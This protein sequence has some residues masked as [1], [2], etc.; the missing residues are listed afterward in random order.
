[1]SIAEATTFFGWCTVLSMSLLVITAVCLAALQTLAI[2]VHTALY[3]I[4]EDQLKIMY[5]DYMAKFKIAQMNKGL[6]AFF[7]SHHC[8]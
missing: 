5:F 2:T 1:M 6:N 3:D 8:A 7:G 4:P